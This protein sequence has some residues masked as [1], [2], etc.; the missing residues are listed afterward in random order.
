MRVI[1]TA[2]PRKKPL[3]PVEAESIIPRHFRQARDLTV[4]EGNKERPL[5]EVFDVMVERTAAAAEEVEVILRGDV[6]RFKRVGEY[7][8]AGKITIEGDIGMQDLEGD[9]FAN[10]FIVCPVYDPHPAGA[11]LLDQLEPSGE[12]LPFAQSFGRCFECF[13]DR[14]LVLH[15][16]KLG[17]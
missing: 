1:L 16:L 9:L 15:N 17:Y 11:Q 6:S 2:K 5:R 10:L 4:W 12:Q 3:I 14:N 13:G 7:M 8:D